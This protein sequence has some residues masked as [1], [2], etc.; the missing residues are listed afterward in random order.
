MALTNG[1]E[2]LADVIDFATGKRVHEQLDLLT[3]GERQRSEALADAIVAFTTEYGRPP[4]QSERNALWAD[5]VHDYHARIQE[6]QAERK[7][8][9]DGR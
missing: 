3:D 5:I 7:A 2:H 8:L 6:L 9:A 4:T 1:P